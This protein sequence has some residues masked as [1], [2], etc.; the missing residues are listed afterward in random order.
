MPLNEIV[1][2]FAAEFH[3]DGSQPPT[4]CFYLPED[5]FANYNQA[6]LLFYAAVP[7]RDQDALPVNDGQQIWFHHFP[8]LQGRTHIPEY[9]PQ[10]AS[11]QTSTKAQVFLKT[12]TANVLTLGRDG[13]CPGED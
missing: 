12:D 6:K 11:T 8:F 3:P 7:A 1:D 10:V 2:S 13:E 9:L 5:M 4:P